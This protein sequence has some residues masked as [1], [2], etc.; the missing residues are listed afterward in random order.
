ML[1]CAYSV[2]EPEICQKAEQY[3]SVAYQTAVGE[4][5]TFEETPYHAIRQGRVVEVEE[6]RIGLDCWHCDV[7]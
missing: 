1:A 3:A 6:G 7:N 5:E 4:D 2:L